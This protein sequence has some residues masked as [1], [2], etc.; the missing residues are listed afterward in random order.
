MINT[1]FDAFKDLTLNSFLYFSSLYSL[2]I[3][4]E[5]ITSLLLIPFMSLMT[6]RNFIILHD[7]GHESYIPDKK[8]NYYIGTFYGILCLTPF[9]W[10]YDHKNHHLTSGNKNNKLDYF[11]NE[12]VP[13]TLKEYQNMNFINKKLY[14]II[15]DPLIFFTIIPIIKFL[16]INRV[17]TL[18]YIYNGYH[19]KKTINRVLYDT[20]INNIGIGLLFYFMY[21]YDI[22][23]HYLVSCT[24]SASLGIILFHNQ[25]TFNPSYVSEQNWNLKDS[26]LKGSSLIEIPKYLDYFTMGIEYHHIHHINTRISGLKLKEFHYK[27]IDKYK[28]IIIL[29]SKDC[30]DNLSLTLYDEE[31]KK[32]ISFNDIQ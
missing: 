8:L 15:R 1:Y 17:F 14:R 2:Y 24:I 23:F 22:L 11:F 27:N 25:H 29:T 3:Y 7:C 28:D 19:Y 20:I 31:N 13:F 30:Y 21:Q 6:L 18:L 26:G 32:Y 5:S 9:C 10:T 4:K 16:F 12:T